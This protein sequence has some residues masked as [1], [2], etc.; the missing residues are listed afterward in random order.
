MVANYPR[1]YVIQSRAN[2]ATVAHQ[3]AYWWFFKIIG[4][5]IWLPLPTCKHKQETPTIK[6]H[7]KPT[8]V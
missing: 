5:I 2:F 4:K 3:L 6:P 1:R 7:L 8:H